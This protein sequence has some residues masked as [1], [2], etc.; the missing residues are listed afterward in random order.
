MNL[1]QIENPAVSEVTTR[2]FVA[3]AA[4]IIIIYDV[5]CMIFG[6]P[7]V[8]HTIRSMDQQVGGL[9]KW[10]WLGLWAH[11]FIPMWPVQNGL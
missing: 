5:F 9:V 3:V 8:S 1:P 2:I 10:A 11:F 6:W 7:T 4:A